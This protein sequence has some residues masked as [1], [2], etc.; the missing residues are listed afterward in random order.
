MVVVASRRAL[1]HLVWAPGELGAA[2][3]FVHGDLRVEGDLHDALAHVWRHLDAARGGTPAGRRIRPGIIARAAVLAVRLGAVGPRPP[4]PESESALTGDLHS[5]SRDRAAISHHYDLS[6]EFYERILDPQLAYS[7]GYHRPGD[8]L[9]QA[10]FAKLE[11]ICE[12]LA[13]QPGMRLLDI[14]CG[15]GALALHAAEHHG[16]AVTGVTLS[17]E[18]RDFVLKRA[19]TR[20]L[21][22]RIDVSLRHYRDIGPT[23][24]GPAVFDAVTSIE[25]GEHVGDAEYRGF[26]A[27]VHDHLRPGGRALVQQMSRIHG[28][29]PGG[30]P[31]IETYIAPDMHMKPL[32]RTLEHFAGA[33]LEVLAVE[34]MREH[35][36][37][38]VAGW[39]ANLTAHHDE[40]VALVGIEMVRVWQLYLAGGS[41]AFEQGRMG[42]DQ[43]LLSRPASPSTAATSED[44]WTS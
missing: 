23:T 14:G 28:D 43:I 42:V 18:Q 12:K 41:L 35:Y 10:Q 20:G 8:T 22:D 1:R 11:L 9:E 25:M 31:F 7:C 37:R 16:V 40:L 32:H 19:A 15:W 30:G 21:S 27:A 36:P 33:G 5:T 3:A 6:N 2:R 26:A 24:T 38:T 34:G 29:H 44:A 13:L 39:S 4:R 17:G